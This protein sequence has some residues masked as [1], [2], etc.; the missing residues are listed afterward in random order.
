MYSQI[1]YDEQVIVGAC[2]CSFFPNWC[3]PLYFYL[4]DNLILLTHFHMR[5]S[6]DHCIYLGWFFM[7]YIHIT[8]TTPHKSP[9]P[10]YT[11][12]LWYPSPHYPE[13]LLQS[14]LYLLS[15]M[16]CENISHKLRHRFYLPLTQTI[17]YFPLY[18]PWH[19]LCN[20]PYYS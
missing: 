19:M 18:S 17:H 4:L 8:D 11:K 6:L 1:K 14:Y 9:R 7:K 20:Q 5:V 12:L 3:V 16:V 10:K 15:W 13:V 2:L